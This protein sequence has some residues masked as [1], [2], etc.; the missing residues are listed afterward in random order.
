MS[1]ISEPGSDPT[2]QASPCPPSDD[3]R[4]L[5]HQLIL[6]QSKARIAPEAEVHVSAGDA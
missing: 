3:A 5:V 6:R 1:D 2:R 4:P